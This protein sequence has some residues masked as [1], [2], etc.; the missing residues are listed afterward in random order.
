MLLLVLFS[1][2]VSCRGGSLNKSSVVSSLTLLS[3]QLIDYNNT[4]AEVNIIGQTSSDYIS[5]DILTFHND[6]SCSS[7]S[8]G[9]SRVSEFISTGLIARIPV[10]T[11][12]D[13]YVKSQA[14]GKCVFLQNYTH[15]ALIPTE[16]VFTQIVP[17]SPSRATSAP[18]LFGVARPASSMVQ[19]FSDSLCSNILAS[20]SANAFAQTGISVQLPLNQTTSIY[21]RALDPVGTSSGC[22]FMTDFT[23]SNTFSPYPELLAITPLSPSSQS[24]TPNIRGTTAPGSTSVALFR[25]SGCLNQLIQGDPAVFQATGFNVTLTANSTT[26]IY[27][28]SLDATATPSVCALF[29][30]FTHDNLPPSNLSF[31]SISPVSPT[32]Q[33]TLPRVSGFVSSDTDEVTFYDTALCVNVIGTGTRA[34]FTSVG[35][36]ANVRTNNTTQIYARAF[37]SSDNGSDCTFMT[38]Y[39]H[40]TVPPLSPTFGQ[41]NPAS[42]TNL[43]TTPLIT[44][45]VS[46]RTVSLNF[47][48]DEFCTLGIGQG[49]TSSYENSGIIVS[50]D[51]NT[52]TSIYVNVLDFE[53]NISECFFHATY[54]H[55]SVPAPNPG[56][57]GTVPASPSRTS[58]TPALLG[59][60][61]PS[62][63]TVSIFSNSICTAQL[64]TGTRG[65]FTSSGIVTTV[66]LNS[67]NNLYARARDIYG[68]FSA[69]V[70]LTTYI[71]NNIAPFAPIYTSV[72]PVSPNNVSSTPT[73]F[74][75]V[76]VNPASQL[77]PLR[78]EF[79][80]D[81]SCSNKLG[82]G[83]PS[84]YLSPGLVI[85]VAGN[86]EATIYGKSF[87]AAG[88]QSACTFLTFYT[89]DNLIPA[90]P[91]FSSISPASPS[92]SRDVRM[93]GAYGF[94]TDFLSRVSLGIYS[95]SS[96]TNL[97]TA[98]NPALLN[99]TGVTFTVA[100]NTMTTL[101]GQTINLVGTLSACQFLTNFT[102]Y[103]LP[104]SNIMATSNINGS[105]NLTW[106]PDS[107]SSPTPRYTV[108]RS[109]KSGGPFTILSSNQIGNNYTDLLV[110]NGVQYFYRVYATNI[111]GRS[112]YTSEVNITISA[113]APVATNALTTSISDSQVDLI[114]S[115]FPQNVTYRIFRSL[116]FAGPFTDLG[117]TT[118]STAYSDVSLIN[119][120]TYYYFIKA[121]NPS[122]ESV[123]SNIASAV[124]KAVSPTP[125]QFSIT[126]LISDPA[127]G[128]SAG[129][130][131]N[132]TSPSYFSDFTV[133][134]SWQKNTLNS[135]GSS[136]IPQFNDCGTGSDNLLYYKVTSGWGPAD[137][138]GSNLVGFYSSSSPNLTLSPGDSNIN[139]TWN[140][141]ATYAG[142][143]SGDLLYTVYKSLD[144]DKN[145][146]VLADAFVPRALNDATLNGAGAYYY[147]QAYLIDVDGDKIY[148][149]YPTP[150]RSAKASINPNAPSN[151]ISNF[152][153][154]TGNL[155]L[156]W[157]SPSHFNNFRIYR[158]TSILGPYS[159]ILTTSNPMVSSATLVAGMNYFRVSAVWGGFETAP[160]NTVAFRNASI[161]GLTLVPQATQLNLSWNAITGASDYVI[162]RSS[163]VNGPFANYAVAPTATY[164]DLSV[165]IDTG[166]YYTVRARFPDLTEGQTSA[167]VLGQTTSVTAK[168]PSNISLTVLGD[169]FVRVDWPRVS[170]AASYTVERALNFAGPYTSA[171]TTASNTL[172]M[173]GLNS[174]QQYFVRVKARISG[175]DYTSSVVSVYT[176]VPTSA[177]SGVVGNN[178]VTITWSPMPGLVDYDIERSTNGVSFIAVS[179]NYSMSSYT[180][181]TATNGSV[182]FYRIKAN[183]IPV[184]LLSQVSIGFSP[185][186]TPLAPSQLNAENNGTGTEALLTWSDISGKTSFN[187]YRSLTSG[188][189]GAPIQNSG[190]ATG[191]TV[192][193]LTSGTK[194]YFRVT[195][196][197]GT[198][199]S[200]VSNEISFIPN[201]NFA[202]P[203]AQFDTSTSILVSWSSIGGANSYNI[204]RSSD[205]IVFQQIASNL[206]TTNFID[207]PIT[208]AITYYYRY[209]PYD[210]AGTEMAMSNVSDAV[211]VSVSPLIPIGLR[212][213]S[214]ATNSVELYWS[215]VP[216]I[217]NYE[218]LRSSTTGGPYAVISSPVMSA[219]NFTDT[220]VTPGQDYFYVLRTVNSSGVRSNNSNEVAV[221][222]VVGPSGLAVSNVP[223][224]VNISWNLVSG[225]TG[226]EVLRS[227]TSTGPFGLVAST[228]SLTTID[229]NVVAA[230]TYYYVVRGTYSSQRK[231]VQSNVVSILRDGSLK[232]QVPIELTDT[233]VS[234]SATQNLS[235][236]RTLTSFNSND[237]D[238][239]SSYELEFIATNVD[240][241]AKAVGIVNASN[242]IVGFVNVPANTLVPTLIKGTITMPVGAQKLRLELQQTS[243]DGQLSVMSAR[244]LVNQVN[245]TKTKIYYPLINSDE[246]PINNDQDIFAYSTS[247]DTYHDFINASHF[248]RRATK[249]DRI[250]TYN[251][252]EL[253]VLVS[254]IGGSEGILGLQN[255]TTSQIVTMTE[256]RFT[257]SGI[258]M[259]TIPFNEGITQFRAANENNNYSLVLRCEYYCGSGSVRVHK[260]GLWVKLRNLNK[261]SIV[262][263][264]GS[265][266]RNISSVTQ[267][268]S[269]RAQ[270]DTTKF[271]APKVYY[272]VMTDTNPLSSGTS[273][274]VYHNANSGSAGLTALSG[275]SV[276]INAA[277]IQ[278]YRSPQIMSMPVD[279]KYISVI[280]PS[281][282]QINLRSSQ[283]L[284]ETGP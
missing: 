172:T 274:L 269:T 70:F 221:S 156:D 203:N 205:G 95:N 209:Q 79:Y 107:F 242:V 121:I 199:E 236:N 163:S 36:V 265:L 152:I 1:L 37:D 231:S 7:P 98:S 73:I 135:Y 214:Q 196:L 213:A 178:Q 262:Y 266:K 233:A 250:E 230:E 90:V 166:Y 35:A 110:S 3:D 280:S 170:N 173:F 223:T 197:N 133:T 32:N 232:N 246:L 127:C 100:A 94:S 217:L 27:A 164:S 255:V 20:G 278:M 191:T 51:T 131:L 49:S 147:V 111:T 45:L 91:L 128:G 43:T 165:T 240:S 179:T 160:T 31:S 146:F 201:S 204:L 62:I 89:F 175:L 97:V 249:L 143:S 69:C 88:N 190:T 271:T 202:K 28:Q 228:G 155:Q 106:N 132:W 195:A 218:V 198:N 96:C 19:F 136:V 177:P 245:A 125:T 108:E 12:V 11:V 105:V 263:R 5:L 257:G 211:N 42:P 13:F 254:T 23:H 124:P 158:A 81:M 50:A 57:F 75:N 72:S 189:Y 21:S 48:K 119:N 64:S 260:A 243:T 219:V 153:S 63:S 162:A 68:N 59:T 282:G 239:V 151:L 234:S 140:A 30:T 248:T 235:F 82:E 181:N 83:T 185:G 117:I 123:Q 18:G 78:V 102:H 252:W 284:V 116:Q 237:Y 272:Q 142:Y 26:I 144:P 122:G 139:L 208:P 207:S 222:L 161:T 259:A 84:K 180:D 275:S 241:S 251:A 80:D 109:I 126:P 273:S 229:T 270:L 256:T 34:D 39:V 93:F 24:F 281:Q 137:S 14:L 188:V 171:G 60:A 226:Y 113:P 120:T 220:T 77:P 145:F 87:D 15:P 101:Y 71:H 92:Y 114:W 264:I 279:Q 247:L 2:Q 238:G 86:Y 38:S 224:G 277:T 76:L 194:Y 40:N 134:R 33:T 8:L 258:K 118:T 276:L 41:L 206:L 168:P 65:Q 141:P 55:S 138:N 154:A 186:R 157:I 261:T 129:A 74:G 9:S 130:R 159:L 52:T 47:F 17:M 148:V 253:E 16:P 104:P 149:G 67:T 56:F 150:V 4:F 216:S 227:L 58:N 192:S 182:Y 215:T 174:Q 212:L 187:I 176:F 283:L 99:S 53:G 29:T 167:V 193:G 61:H 25:D 46:E 54:A 267:I 183:Y 268:T 44:G 10:N 115:G 85:G 244:L 112:Q 200:A 6:S 66:P 225:V 184:Q 169:T 210:N 103:D 22:V